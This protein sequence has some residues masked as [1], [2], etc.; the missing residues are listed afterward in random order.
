MDSFKKTFRLLS[1]TLLAFNT[2]LI[3]TKAMLMSRQLQDAAP[4]SEASSARSWSSEFCVVG[5]QNHDD[6]QDSIVSWYHSPGLTTTFVAAVGIL[7]DFQQISEDLQP[8]I[9]VSSAP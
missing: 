3:S 6:C 9:A 5:H 8:R 1:E 4:P 2:I 7:Q